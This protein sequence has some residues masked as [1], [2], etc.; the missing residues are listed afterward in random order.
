MRSCILILAACALALAVG[1]AFGTGAHYIATRPSLGWNTWAEPDPP[2]RE[3]G[4]PRLRRDLDGSG[5]R[6][7]RRGDRAREPWAGHDPARGPAKAR[8]AYALTP[9]TTQ[10]LHFIVRSPSGV[11]SIR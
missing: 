11:S 3:V 7:A 8:R 6:A 1:I 5:V 10:C 2:E 4:D 9:M